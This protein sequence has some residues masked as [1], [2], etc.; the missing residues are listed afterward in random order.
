MRLAT[1][2]TPA[3]VVEADRAISCP[4]DNKN[5]AS[6]FLSLQLTS[7]V[8][9]TAWVKHEEIADA[10][11]RIRKLLGEAA[12]AMADEALRQ[13]ALMVDR[14]D[15]DCADDDW[16]RIIAAVHY[17]TG[18][19]EEGFALINKWSR[20][21]TRYC[22]ELELRTKWR[23]FKEYA[24]RPVT[25]R[26]VRALLGKQG[27]DWIEICAAAEPDFEVC[28]CEVAPPTPEPP[29]TVMNLLTAFS[30]ARQA[31]AAETG[32]GRAGASAR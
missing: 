27:D 13:L 29:M 26:T 9:C 7:A 5:P 28:E 32:N 30:H 15:P 1:R 17:E 11:H 14:L 6:G 2:V 25:I 24:G 3:V 23:S 20:R 16:F 12:H 18:G 21:G 10:E 4:S 22:G 8:H 19:S 31:E